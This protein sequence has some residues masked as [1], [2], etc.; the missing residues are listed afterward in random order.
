MNFEV[1]DN[2][3]TITKPLV[4]VEAAF[5][6]VNELKNMSEKG[7][8]SIIVDMQNFNSLPSVVIGKLMVLKQKGIDV[9]IIVPNELAY[10]LFEDLGLLNVF[11][12]KLAGNN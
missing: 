12:V 7:T 8:K 10:T 11:D 2:K 1:N 6:L 4:D 5:A 3:I 9:K